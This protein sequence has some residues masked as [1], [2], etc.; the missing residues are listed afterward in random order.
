MRV[1]YLTDNLHC[2]V[3]GS[4]DRIRF[5]LRRLQ[6][7]RPS[8]FSPDTTPAVQLKHDY[9]NL[10]DLAMEIDVLRHQLTAPRA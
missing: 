9:E 8:G 2:A 5:F 7:E 3:E 4:I 6:Q 1:H 10:L